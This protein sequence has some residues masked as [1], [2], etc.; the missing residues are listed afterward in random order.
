LVLKPF[1]RFFIAK[2]M[3]KL[4]SKV[5]KLAREN[6]I[7]PEYYFEAHGVP[8]A[9]YSKRNAE[10]FDAN[11]FTCEM[12]G[13]L[14]D[15]G[16]TVDYNP[17]RASHIERGMEIAYS[18]LT[19]AGVPS[20]YKNRIIDT[21][22]THDDNLEENSPLENRIVH[23]SDLLVFYDSIP[24]NMELLSGFGASPG[25]SISRLKAEA[26]KKLP[27]INMEY[28]KGVAKEKHAQF[29][30]NLGAVERMVNNGSF[31]R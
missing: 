25:E 19:K 24:A 30:A 10:L 31:K 8:V 5:Y 18:V 16:Y 7:K 14:H 13:L 9:K 22:R 27:W 1:K 11:S 2:V 21:I 29:L 6:M 12:G 15:I 4:K 20:D 28:F 23:D 26:D 17:E 3:E